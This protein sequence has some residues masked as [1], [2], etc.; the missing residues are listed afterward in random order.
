MMPAVVMAIGAI[1]V[2][3]ASAG[4]AS[5][6]GRS[7]LIAPIFGGMI[8]PLVAAIATWVIVS[9]TFRRNPAA[10]TKL[11]IGAFGV[12]AVFFGIY[13]VAMVKLFDLDVRPF[14]LSFAGFFIS[15]YAVEAALFSR[16][17]RRLIQEPK[18]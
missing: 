6:Q 18:A 11:M 4:I 3:A 17:F 7:D 13:C 1:G 12:K 15:L 8:G 9:A 5:A 16:L 2:A 14:G 10:L